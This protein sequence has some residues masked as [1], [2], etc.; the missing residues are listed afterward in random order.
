MALIGTGVTIELVS[1]YETAITGVT[2]VKA[3]GVFTKSSHGLSD[4]DYVLVTCDG[5]PRLNGMIARIASSDTNTFKLEDDGT[6]GGFV[7]VNSMSGTAVTISVQ[8]VKTWI[9]AGSARSL[10]GEQAEPDRIDV[11]L[12]SSTS[13]QFQFGFA[14]EQSFTVENLLSPASAATALIRGASRAKTAVPMRVTFADSTKMTVNCY[15][16]GGSGFAMEQGQA[17]TD[18]W[19]ALAVAEEVWYSA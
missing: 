6:T 13:K 10:S 7:D 5:I 8:E 15:W 12:L 16:T 2:V 3:T 11:T 14:G 9:T 17:A 4:G 1:A 19:R 18:T